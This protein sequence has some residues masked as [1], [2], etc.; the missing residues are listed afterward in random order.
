MKIGVSKLQ[1]LRTSFL[2]VSFSLKFFKLLLQKV[3]ILGISM[4]APGARSTVRN[5]SSKCGCGTLC[6]SVIC[7]RVAVFINPGTGGRVMGE[8]TERAGGPFGV[9]T[10][11][12]R[13]TSNEPV[14]G[15]TLTHFL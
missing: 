14:T 8:N 15:D 2:P 1:H 5:M 12:V 4:T 7:T 9:I 10:G 11:G 13:G 6:Y 3:D